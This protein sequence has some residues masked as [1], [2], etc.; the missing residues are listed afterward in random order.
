MALIFD[1]SADYITVPANA[2]WNFSTGEFGF[3]M[4]CYMTDTRFSIISNGRMG[5][6]TNAWQLHHNSGDASKTYFYYQGNWAKYKTFPSAVFTQNQWVHIGL[7][8]RGNVMYVFQNGVDLDSKAFTDD[9]GTEN[10]TL[11][12]GWGQVNAVNYYGG[13]I[14]DVRIYKGR[15]L[16]QTDIK[17]LYEERG[18]DTITDGMEL[19]MRMNYG[20]DGS[21]IAASDTITGVSSN[22][23]VGTI[24]NVQTWQAAPLK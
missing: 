5:T 11:G 14:D 6:D 4:W 19:R 10:H 23:S 3:C 22:S 13:S 18:G 15:A 17:I 2:G 12:I 1:G 24:Q 21:T 9:M 16:S 20:A 8:R 7:T